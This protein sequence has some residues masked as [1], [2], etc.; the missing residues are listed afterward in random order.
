MRWYS[1][2]MSE[3][4]T[5]TY[6]S[7]WKGFNVPSDVIHEFLH[8]PLKELRNEYDWMFSDITSKIEALQH[9]PYYLIGTIKG[10]TSTLAHETS[11]AMWRLLPGY[12]EKSLE[13]LTMIPK[14]D[15]QKMRRSLKKTGYA[16]AVLDDEIVAYLSTGLR[17]GLEGFA[18]HQPAF[19]RSFNSH[20]KLFM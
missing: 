19:K 8:A 3:D 17:G 20:K 12:K 6:T 16:A 13:L 9:G 10:D 15:V 11:H 1:L 7:D 4:G 5:F 14:Q 2:N 18:H